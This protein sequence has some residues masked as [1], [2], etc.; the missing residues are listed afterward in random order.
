MLLYGKETWAFTVVLVFIELFLLAAA[1]NRYKDSRSVQLSSLLS[2]RVLSS[3]KV[4]VCVWSQDIFEDYAANQCCRSYRYRAVFVCSPQ[5]MSQAHPFTG[6]YLE[7]VKY[8]AMY[9]RQSGEDIVD[10][11]RLYEQ[12]FRSQ[13]YCYR[14]LCFYIVKS[15]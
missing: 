10:G 5:V 8:E 12:R 2:D 6:A 7:F 11:Y 1:Y 14:R 9:K 4:E 15:I 13:R 3:T